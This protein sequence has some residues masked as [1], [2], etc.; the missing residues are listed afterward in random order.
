MDSCPECESLCVV[1]MVYGKPSIELMD[2][3]A[4]G[5][6]VLAGCVTSLQQPNSKC[7]KCQFEW[8]KPQV[9]GLSREEFQSF[10]RQFGD[11][12]ERGEEKIGALLDSLSQESIEY[13][14][15]LGGAG[16]VAR[17]RSMLTARNSITTS[18]HEISHR[19]SWDSE[20]LES[21]L[22]GHEI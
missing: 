11:F 6:V 10:S 20:K 3:A 18:L 17:L 21:L 4:M 22:Y 7:L 15:E 8:N 16:A 5:L 2:A 12:L 9:P 14:R 13:G 1:P 19:F